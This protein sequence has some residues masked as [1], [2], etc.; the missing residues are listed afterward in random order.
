MQ[1]DEM[2]LLGEMPD[3]I[4]AMGRCILA[5][6]KEDACFITLGF[7]SGVVAN[8]LL[9]WADAN[10]ARVVEVVGSKARIV[11]D[12][13]NMQEPIRIFEKGVSIDTSGSPDFGK[14]KFY[15]R[16]GDIISPKI[17]LDEPLKTLR[18]EFIDA[19]RSRIP[20]ITDGVF[21]CEIV[22]ILCKV[23]G[24]LKAQR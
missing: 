11:F 4:Q 22:K 20:P 24:I 13:L 3:R 16:D 14:F 23:E 15:F 9:S 10:K 2:P 7:P 19:L 18:N 17:Q 21:G 8:V 1:N 5:N 6:N 12:D